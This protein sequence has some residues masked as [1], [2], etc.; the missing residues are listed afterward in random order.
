[1]YAVKDGL[2]NWGATQFQ[3]IDWTI[4]GWAAE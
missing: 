4:V 3:T 1:V 2:V